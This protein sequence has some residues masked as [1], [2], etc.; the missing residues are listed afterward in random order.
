[1]I[2]IVI[3]SNEAGGTSLDTGD[4]G[5][6]E[7][8]SRLL[9]ALILRGAWGRLAA[10]HGTSDPKQVE[11]PATRLSFAQRW[12]ASMFL[13]LDIARKNRRHKTL[14]NFH[15]RLLNVSLNPVDLSCPR[16]W[17]R[18]SPERIVI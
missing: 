18:V 7:K 3:S 8:T 1:M 10:R 16:H 9:D 4:V 13:S 15:R 14:P 6:Q 17:L 11:Q 5:K 12:R 2:D